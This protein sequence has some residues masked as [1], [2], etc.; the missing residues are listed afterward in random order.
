MQSD[1]LMEMLRKFSERIYPE[2][3]RDHG[4]FCGGKGNMGDLGPVDCVDQCC[5]EHD[6]CYSEGNIPYDFKWKNYDFVMSEGATGDI[7][8]NDCQKTGHEA[9]HLCAKCSCDRKFATC[10]KG[11][12]EVPLSGDLNAKCP[13]KASANYAA[14]DMPKTADAFKARIVSFVS[15]SAEC[16]LP[17][18]AAS[19][20]RM[21]GIGMGMG[22]HAMGCHP[23][24]EMGGLCGAPVGPHIRPPT[25][26][27]MGQPMG[28]PRR[29]PIGPPQP[30]RHPII[31][32][33]RFPVRPVGPPMWPPVMPQ[34]MQ[35]YGK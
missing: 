25:V 14:K 20:N 3:L 33:R 10:L 31:P 30:L 6:M 4:Y 7:V 2:R 8:C 5:Y 23:W 17:A 34:M 28:P 12:P 29:R 11:K 1:D 16:K 26:Q 9:L 27:P 24:A 22:A 13:P 21:M 18:K 35:M 32:P 19:Q 15:A